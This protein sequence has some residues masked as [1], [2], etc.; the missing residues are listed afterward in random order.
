MSKLHVVMYHYVRDLKHSRYPEIKGLHSSYFREQLQ[1]LKSNFTI[2]TIEDVMEAYQGVKTLPPNAALL[3]FDDGYIDHFTNVFPLLMT[4]KVQGS[5]F[6]PGITFTEHKLLDVNKIHFVL[7]S[8]NIN[9]LVEELYQQ[10]N[11]YRGNEFDLPSNEELFSQHAVATRFDSKETIFVK[12]LLQTVLPERL[13]NMITSNIFEKY[14]GLSE[15]TFARE[16]YMNT[17]QIK[18]MKD[19]GMF[20]GLHGYDHYWLGNLSEDEM[21]NDIEKAL[22]VMGD[23]IDK[24]AWVM[25]YP[26]GSYNENV[27]RYVSEQGCKLGFTT[28]VRIADIDADNRYT[29]PR[30]DTNDYPPKS[31]HYRRL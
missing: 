27:T 17:D 18:C 20:I 4:E 24:D 29:I 31:D 8:T 15:E 16:L 13:R 2:V 11:Y 22:A 10:L 26:Y 1:F 6:I 25:N 7:A 14:V 12:R 23:F 21:K 30:L 3:T 9:T 28:Q 19:S 5:F